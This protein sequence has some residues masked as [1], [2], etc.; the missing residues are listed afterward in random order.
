MSGDVTGHWADLARVQAGHV[1]KLTAEVLELR[2]NKARLAAE[3]HALD[4]RCDRY[5]AALSVIE[6][7]G[8]IRLLEGHGP[9]DCSD[10]PIKCPRCI[11]RAALQEKK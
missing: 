6:S 3:Y 1:E 4:A 8:C 9:G 11:A 5:K 10:S 7:L 2:A